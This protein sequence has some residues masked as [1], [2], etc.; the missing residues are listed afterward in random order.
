MY[1]YLFSKVDIQ[2]S[3]I[4]TKQNKSLHRQWDIYTI[5]HN[6]FHSTSYA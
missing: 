1:S 2:D 5:Y 4:Y 6:S 3:D